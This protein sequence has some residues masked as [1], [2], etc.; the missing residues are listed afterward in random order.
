MI[1]AAVS[2]GV[3]FLAFG[4]FAAVLA[5]GGNRQ[6]AALY[7][8]AAAVATAA[9]SAAVAIAALAGSAPDLADLAF[10]TIRSGTWIAFLYRLLL[11]SGR[12]RGLP[13]FRYV[14]APGIIF[15]GSII[16]ADT[17]IGGGFVNDPLI[18]GYAMIGRLIIPVAALT[19][20]ENL[21]RDDWQNAQWWA[22]FLFIGL[23]TFFAYDL[24]L[25]S[26]TLL[27]RRVNFDLYAVRGA[28]DTIA[29]PLMAISFARN[30]TFAVDIH[31]SRRFV[32]HSMTLGLTGGYFLLM[33]FAGY[34]L[35]DF[36]GTWGTLLQVT[37]LCAA[38]V[39]VFLAISSGTFRS[40]LRNFVSSNFFSYKY[41]YRHEWLQFIGLIS[42]QESL[43]PLHDR[44][45][46]AI[47]NIVDSPGGSFWVRREG[48]EVFVNTA[49]WNVPL[50]HE[51][52]MLPGGLIEL[53]EGETR[54]LDITAVTGPELAS[55]EVPGWLRSLPRAWV[56]L[57]LIHRH[58]L[59]GLLLLT[60]PRA[61]RSLTDEDFALLITVGRQAASYIAE[62]DAGRALMDSRQLE[63]FNQ[64]FAFVVHD[65]KNLVSQ[66]SL[67][68]SNAERHGANPEF[69]HD[70]LA[71]VGHSVARMKNLLEQLS[72]ARRAER[73]AAS[74][75]FAEAIQREWGTAV[76]RDPRLE[77]QT[78]ATRCLV[79][80]DQETVMQ[81][82]RHVVQN[83]LEAVS[84][85]GHV[86][87]IL[88]QT[89][90]FALL[91]II[92]DGPGMTAEFIRDELFRPFK[93]TKKTGYG[94]GA[95]QAR[96][97]IRQSGGRLD[98][99]STP[100]SGTRVSI[101]LPLSAVTAIRP[102][103]VQQA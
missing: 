75:D 78:P 18:S 14:L 53:L 35:R 42:A 6:G 103:E 7:L 90:E 79:N 25:Y 15:F 32:F 26:E 96:E 89:S 28:V 44:V 64:R 41:D 81:V 27:F 102:P 47:A 50:N 69:Q 74:F 54:V 29:V 86:R 83:A 97:L 100:A 98:V 60:L 55:G 8:M 91:K 63:L 16:L 9:W 94:I 24:F 70:V 38:I 68:L 1:V 30:P 93:T 12:R 17:L 65:I 95:Y 57:P 51:P 87:L 59:L 36:G 52:Q 33:A 37:F 11:E 76:T 10:E 19:L 71:T 13:A 4:A 43:L 22:R 56:L 85:A 31:V 23:G 84:N 21:A 77:V 48:D 20:I 61:P 99:S 40:A 92:D 73:E 49:A 62:E 67:I 3:A 46:Q 101:Q 88:Q 45:I 2:H 80:S 82:L 72:L 39:L 5:L 34:Y 58:R 66:L